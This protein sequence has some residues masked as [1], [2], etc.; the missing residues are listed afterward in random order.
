MTGH[1]HKPCAQYMIKVLLT[2][3]GLVY[4][5]G[6]SMRSL[7]L[8]SFFITYGQEFGSHFSSN[9]DFM[10]GSLQCGN[11]PLVFRVPFHSG[12]IPKK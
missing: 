10:A 6:S 11:H 8:S 1:H 12:K 5:E 3:I 4:V 2:V 7:L 9:R